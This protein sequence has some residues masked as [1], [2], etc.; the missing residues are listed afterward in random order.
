M[1]QHFNITNGVDPLSITTLDFS[2]APLGATRT[3]G[4]SESTTLVTSHLLDV[5]ISQRDL[6]KPVPL[7]YSRLS[8]VL[9]FLSSGYEVS[10]GA[11]IDQKLQVL[12]VKG[13]VKVTGTTARKAS[14][15]P[16]EDLFATD[17]YVLPYAEEQ[18]VEG[19]T[20]PVEDSSGAEVVV[21][22]E[23]VPDTA[24]V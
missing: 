19:S 4:S 9:P 20:A 3:L 6:S 1:N 17:W 21:E 23:V 14:S 16:I 5:V 12:P 15:I 11:W 24:V 18:V 13:L 10:R 2:G 22:A 8:Y 7:Y